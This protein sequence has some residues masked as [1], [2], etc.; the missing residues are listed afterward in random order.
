MNTQDLWAKPYNPGGGLPEDGDY[1]GRANEAKV[2]VLDSGKEIFEIPVTVEEGQYAGEKVTIAFFYMT[3]G[4]MNALK[5]AMN[6]TDKR[7][8]GL[9]SLDAA[10]ES[11][12]NLL[13]GRKVKFNQ[14][15]KDDKCYYNL[16]EVYD[17]ATP[18]DIPMSTAAPEQALF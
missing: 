6:K 10:L 15:T 12:V 16:V 1:Y 13:T 11:M 14:K 4:G 3:E 9:S 5:S 18:S 8:L 7:I 17:Q 2:K